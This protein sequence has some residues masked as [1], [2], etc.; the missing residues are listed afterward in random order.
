MYIS[1]T[2]FPETKHK[3]DVNEGRPFKRHKGHVDK[4]NYDPCCDV[5]NTITCRVDFD[6]Q[7]HW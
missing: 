2:N 6:N 7:A 5:I 1:S 3:F 4:I